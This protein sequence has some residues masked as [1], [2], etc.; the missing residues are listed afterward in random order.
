MLGWKK[1]LAFHSNFNNCPKVTLLGPKILATVTH[2]YNMQTL[3]TQ[4]ILELLFKSFACF[5]SRKTLPSIFFCCMGHC[6]GAAWGCSA[7]SAWSATEG[8]DADRPMANFSSNSDLR[9]G[10]LKYKTEHLST[11][12]GRP[13]CKQI[14]EYH[15]KH[16]LESAS[17]LQDSL[18][19]SWGVPCILASGQGESTNG[20]LKE[21]WSCGI[22]RDAMETVHPASVLKRLLPP[23]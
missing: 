16:Y 1:T 12:E 6:E 17:I 23:S 13:G 2:F 3:C 18:K 4:T 8:E 21:A 9:T 10:H 22:N 5:S 11:T 15:Q 20:L 19:K 7:T 14:G